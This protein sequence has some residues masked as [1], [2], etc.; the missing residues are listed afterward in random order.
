[1]PDECTQS[2]PKR[3]V[4]ETCTYST[5]RRA[6]LTRPFKVHEDKSEPLTSTPEKSGRQDFMCDQCAKRFKTRYR[7]NI[8]KKQHGGIFKHVCQVC[9]K[10]YNQT[11]QFRFH[12]AR[13]QNFPSASCRFCK[14]TFTGHSSLQRHLSICS[15]NPD[16]VTTINQELTCAECSQTFSSKDALSYHTK[17]KHGTARYVCDRCGKAYS[18]RSSL[19]AH[20]ACCK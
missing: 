17:G 14:K 6:N 16:A 7:L 1:M 3:F 5:N 19:R 18:W 4:C 2:P 9:T 13:H 20:K 11:T 12:Y 8:H 10:G 15:S